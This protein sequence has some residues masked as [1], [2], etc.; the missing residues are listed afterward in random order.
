MIKQTKGLEVS[1]KIEHR[2]SI[3]VRSFSD[4]KVRSMKDLFK[5]LEVVYVV[6]GNPAF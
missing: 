1:S 5:A 6:I 4:E 2:H 3:Y